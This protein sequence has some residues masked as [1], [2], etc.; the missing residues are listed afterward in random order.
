[1][2][3]QSRGAQDVLDEIRHVIMHLKEKDRALKH[4]V[5]SLSALGTGSDDERI[6]NANAEITRLNLQKSKLQTD[7]E[8][9]KTNV[10]SLENQNDSLQQ[11]LNTAMTESNKF[12]K[13]FSLCCL[14]KLEIRCSDLRTAI[15]GGNCARS[16][17][18]LSSF[19]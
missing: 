14:Y 13:L 18:C 7:L 2:S 12:E 16:I 11:Q 1:M 6:R 8:T 4:Q 17:F 3:G 15:C 19:N 9:M 10:I 5:E